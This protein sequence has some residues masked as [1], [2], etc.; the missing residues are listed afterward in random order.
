MPQRFF[1]LYPDLNAIS[2]PENPT[3]PKNFNR[4]WWSPSGE[5]RAYFDMREAFNAS[6]FDFTHPA[7]DNAAR[8][9]R[10][11]Y[12][13]ATSFT[14]HQFGRVLR[15]LEESPFADTTI[16]LLWSD[17]GW[18]LGDTNSWAKVTNFETAARNV[19]LWKVP[20]SMIGSGAGHNSPLALG[21]S[22]RIVEMVDLYPTLIELAGLPSLPQCARDQGPEDGHCLEGISYASAFGVGTGVP[23]DS[24][25]HQWPYGTYLADACQA[26][27][28][29]SSGRQIPCAVGV[30]GMPAN[31]NCSTL[32]GNG[33]IKGPHTAAEAAARLKHCPRTM[34][35]AIRTSSWRYVVSVPYSGTRYMPLSWG[36]TAMDGEQLYNYEKDPYESENVAGNP[37]NQKVIRELRAT[38]EA[39]VPALDSAA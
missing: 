17:H 39:R 36:E 33:G 30:G 3:V 13:A 15:Q 26:G 22:T 21:R 9:L 20:K 31:A 35:Y 16:T 1:D 8:K 34:A 10:R 19:M 6:G 28:S 29:G 27:T 38:L 5:V 14:D 25:V 24:A 23:R 32:G 7:N 2:L 4:D 12:F 37:A 18:H 11:G